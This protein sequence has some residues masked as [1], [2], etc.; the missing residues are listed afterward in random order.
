MSKIG[1]RM[2]LMRKT[3]QRRPRRMRVLRTRIKARR[4]RSTPRTRRAKRR[5]KK[6]RR[7]RKR[8]HCYVYIVQ[9]P[10]SCRK[11]KCGPL[12]PRCTTAIS[13]SYGTCMD[14]CL[15][16]SMLHWGPVGRLTGHCSQYSHN[17]IVRFD[18]ESLRSR[19]KLKIPRAFFG[20]ILK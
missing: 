3:A 16:M 17:T 4:G 9:H 15:R 5:S 7:R 1:I 20:N 6:L 2:L 13:S 19:S 14:G 10:T 18:V 8:Q 12:L 11:E